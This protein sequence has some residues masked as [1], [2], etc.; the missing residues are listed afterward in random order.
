MA[1]VEKVLKA[2]VKA[3]GG[4]RTEGGVFCSLAHSRYVSVRKSTPTQ[5]CYNYS[6]EPHR[7]S[8]WKQDRK[9]Q[10]MLLRGT[11]CSCF[12]AFGTKED[13]MQMGDSEA[14]IGL[15]DS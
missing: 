12:S 5:K 14:G 2:A 1:S 3:E 8:S 9:R 15:Q 7:G 13:S 4:L 10:K 6:F 11:A